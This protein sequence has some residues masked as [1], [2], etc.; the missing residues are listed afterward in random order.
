MRSF[1]V[2]KS[3]EPIPGPPP[4]RPVEYA[5]PPPVSNGSLPSGD[6]QRVLPMTKA[7]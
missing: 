2:A 5:R 4:R 6:D 1:D 7:E 3:A